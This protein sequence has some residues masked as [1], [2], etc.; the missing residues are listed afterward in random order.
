MSYQV[1][2]FITVSYKECSQSWW[3]MWV[4]YLLSSSF[5]L[6]PDFGIAAKCLQSWNNTTN[7]VHCIVPGRTLSCQVPEE[8]TQVSLSFSTSSPFDH[9]LPSWRKEW[10]TGGTFTSPVFPYCQG[11]C[12]LP[13]NLTHFFSRGR[14]TGASDLDCKVYLLLLHIPLMCHSLS[15]YLSPA[16]LPR[17]PISPL[18]LVWLLLKNNPYFKSGPIF[19]ESLNEWTC[20]CYCVT[21]SNWATGYESMQSL[22]LS[23]L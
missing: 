12:R 6:A 8:G 13:S 19:T 18:M 17:P 2:R 5:E 23:L 21:L 20:M 16:V 10:T 15:G 14:L 7:S 22:L 9:L 1:T 4:Q 11:E 3:Q